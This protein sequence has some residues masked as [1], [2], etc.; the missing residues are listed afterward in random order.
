[1]VHINT[2]VKWIKQIQD[3]SK[4]ILRLF[5]LV[6]TYTNEWL[7]ILHSCNCFKLSIKR[8]NFIII[9]DVK[10]ILG[11]IVVLYHKRFNHT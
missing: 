6:N 4:F 2:L 8:F 5:L 10:Q 9:I 3:F 1:M 11:Y 7:F